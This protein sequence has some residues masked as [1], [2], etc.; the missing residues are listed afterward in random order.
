VSSEV[1][2]V[3]CIYHASIMRM[4]ILQV[5]NLPD[6]LHVLLSERARD[7]GVSMSELVTQTLARELARPSSRQW[8]AQI[9]ATTSPRPTRRLDVAQALDEAREEYDPR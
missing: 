9:R 6:D 4:A 8:V 5:R 7:E 3:S 2:L 1:S